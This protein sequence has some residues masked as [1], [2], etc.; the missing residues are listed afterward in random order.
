MHGF[1]SEAAAVRMSREVWLIRQGRTA[2]GRVIRVP[3]QATVEVRMLAHEVRASRAAAR[4]READARR[5]AARGLDVLSTWQGSFGS[6]D[7][8]TSVAMHGRGLVLSGL[9]SA[10]RSRRP[11]VVFEWSERTR[12]LSQQVVPLRPPPDAELADELAELRRLRSEDPAWI[13]S[14]RAAEL[15]EHARERQWSGTL[16]ASIEE[17]TTLDE[18]RAHLDAHTALVAYVYSGLGLSALVVTATGARLVDVDGF[19]AVRRALPGLRADLDMAASIR[20]SAMAGVVRRSL[21]ERLADLSSALLDVPL[22]AAGDVRRIVITAPG[23][24]SGI[25]WGMLPAMRGR[26]FTL[27]VSAT[28]WVRAR[29]RAAAS[30]VTTVGIRRRSARRARR[31]GGRPSPRRAWPC[32]TAVLRG[33]V[34]SVAAVTALASRGRCAP[35]RRARSSRG[36]QPAVLGPRA[37]RRHAVRLRHRPDARTCP[38]PSCSRRARSDA[39]RCAGARRR[40]G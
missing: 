8:Q 3:P 34:A 28:R 9:E 32:S 29:G 40:S 2:T 19:P 21:D 38:T 6:L 15:R 27:A 5:H 31:R 33:D 37:R 13:D 1:R 39:R 26:A 22:S 7:L 18:V 11:D 14:P 10:L 35:R 4:G 16:A 12:H 36:R 30:A 24:L 17:R 20:G 23:L 25:P